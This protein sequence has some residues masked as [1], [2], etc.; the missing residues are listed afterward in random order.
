MN[1][2]FSCVIFLRVLFIHWCFSGPFVEYRFKQ[3][4]KDSKIES[5]YVYV[6]GCCIRATRS[7]GSSF[8]SS[9]RWAPAGR[10]KIETSSGV[11][12]MS[13]GFWH[14]E[15]SRVAVCVLAPQWGARTLRY[16]PAAAHWRL[17]GGGGRGLARIIFGGSGLR[18]LSDR[19]SRIVYF[20]RVR[21]RSLFCHVPYT[22]TYYSLVVPYE[23]RDRILEAKKFSYINEHK[24]H[25]KFPKFLIY[26]NEVRRKYKN[27]EI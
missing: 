13:P 16:V 17:E 8:F 21:L 1:N 6:Y 5:R 7:F 25:P 9:T 22:T 19:S 15:P 23:G 3:R 10:L 11:R 12:T 20:R 18:E 27:T 2:N 4:S 24:W 26:H 14:W